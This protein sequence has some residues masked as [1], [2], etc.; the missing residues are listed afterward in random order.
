[1]IIAP[2]MKDRDGNIYISRNCHAELLGRY[3]DKFRDCETGFV[4][5]TCR[6]VDRIEAVRIAKENNQII[7]KHGSDNELY[8][9]DVFMDL[10][11]RSIDKASSLL[12]EYEDAEE[13]GRLV[14]LEKSWCI[15]CID[16]PHKYKDFCVVELFHQTAADEIF[17]IDLTV[18]FCPNCGRKIIHKDAEQALKERSG[19]DD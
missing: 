17:E 9:E 1:M 13:Q 8:S 5:D 11:G 2:A 7:R 18:N 16:V 19:E 14:I 15:Y 6:F 4:T 3:P 10:K 12:A